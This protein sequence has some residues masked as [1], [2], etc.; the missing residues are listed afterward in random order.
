MP[1]NVNRA[2]AMLDARIRAT[3]TVAVVCFLTLAP[4][5]DANER[6]IPLL[7]CTSD[8]HVTWNR[9]LS[10]R[11]SNQWNDQRSK[12]GRRIARLRLHRRWSS[13]Q[14]TLQYASNALESPATHTVIQHHQLAV[15]HDS[16]ILRSSREWL[17]SDRFD[18]QALWRD[19]GRQSDFFLL[20]ET[21]GGVVNRSALIRIFEA[22]NTTEQSIL[23]IEQY[24][25]GIESG[26]LHVDTFINGSLPHPQ[27]NLS[28]TVGNSNIKYIKRSLGSYSVEVSPKTT[29][30]VRLLGHYDSKSSLSYTLKSKTD[31]NSSTTYNMNYEIEDSL[32]YYECPH[33]PHRSIKEIVVSNQD[34][35]IYHSIEDSTIRFFSITKFGNQGTLNG[36]PFS[37]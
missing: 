2:L 5:F 20:V 36:V 4:D 27:G 23:N 35:H 7:R 13:T 15:R 29:F 24:F 11:R 8:V 25:H 14:F 33:N 10:C 34:N 28:V 30:V 18:R 6:V 9:K 19:G 32:T 31:T 22:D 26:V 17:R 3:A 21:L 37:A 12:A 1:S 16:S